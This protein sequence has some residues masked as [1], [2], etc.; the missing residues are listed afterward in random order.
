MNCA[1][2]GTEK[3]TDECSL[4]SLFVIGHFTYFGTTTFSGSTGF[5][6]AACADVPMPSTATTAT[7]IATLMLTSLSMIPVFAPASAVSAAHRACHLAA[8]RYKLDLR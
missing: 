3:F 4:G 6:P 7:A 1:Q 2:A 8:A 5:A